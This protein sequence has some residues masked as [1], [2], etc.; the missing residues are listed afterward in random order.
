ML[1][2]MTPALWHKDVE[3]FVLQSRSIFI[4]RGQFS[5]FC[6]AKMLNTDNFFEQ[7]FRMLEIRKNKAAGLQNYSSLSNRFTKLKIIYKTKITIVCGK[8]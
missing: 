4:S 2:G 8:T 7:Q 5:N 1:T 3:E 6:I